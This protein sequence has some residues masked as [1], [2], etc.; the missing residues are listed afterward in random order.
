M[1]DPDLFWNIGSIEIKKRIQDSIF[2][3]GLT[4]DCKT[5][6]GTAKLSESYLLINEIAQKGDSNN[7]MVAATGIE[8]VTLG[9]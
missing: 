6:F 7:T 4:Y 1:S 3:E 5:G 9:L 2:P 8:P